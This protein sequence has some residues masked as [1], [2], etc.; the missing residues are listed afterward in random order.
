MSIQT[1]KDLRWGLEFESK[2]EDLNTGDKHIKASK[3][4]TGSGFITI[5]SV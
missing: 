4:N 1:E 5:S 2:Y 3:E